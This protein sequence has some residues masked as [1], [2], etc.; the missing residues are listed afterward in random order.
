MP[1]VIKSYVRYV[2]AINRLVGRGALYLLFVM[3]GV[4]LFSAISRFFFNHPV[5][6]AVEFTQFVMA[7]YFMLGGGFSMLLGSHVRMDVF[8]SK[9]SPRKQARMDVLTFIVLAGYLGFLLYGCCTSTWYSIVFNQH[10]NSAW[11][12]PLAPVK[13]IMGIG[14]VLT[15]L[16]AFSEFFKSLA[17]W[18]GVLIEDNI[19]ERL[20]LEREAE[21]EPE[22][23]LHGSATGET[24]PFP[25]HAHVNA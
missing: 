1:N 25:E 22:P 6:W 13:V 20:L 16:Q 18:H 12:P 23:A 8:Y 15:L 19:P 7:A 14:I 10:N 21:L 2:D 24:T 17:R 3:M 11:A 9:W 5:L 4:L